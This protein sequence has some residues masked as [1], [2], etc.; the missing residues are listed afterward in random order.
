MVFSVPS[1]T[2]VWCSPSVTRILVGFTL[3]DNR[4]RQKTSGHLGLGVS[5]FTRQ[6]SGLR[7]PAICC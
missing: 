3:N 7:S 1:A 5:C 2:L 6:R 4:K